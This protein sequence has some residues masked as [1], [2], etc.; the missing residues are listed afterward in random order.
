LGTPDY[1]EGQPLPQSIDDAAL[2]SRENVLTEWDSEHGPIN[3]H[4]KSIYRSDGWLM[5]CYGPSHL[6][7]GSEGEPLE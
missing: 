5:T 4:L 7:D 1:C 2:Q 3:M 6:Y